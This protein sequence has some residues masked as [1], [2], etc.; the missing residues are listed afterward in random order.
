MKANTK[1]NQVVRAVGLGACLL[2]S[3]LN[4]SAQSLAT[5]PV[6]VTL[7]QNAQVENTVIKLG[8]LAAID[9]DGDLAERLSTVVVGQSPRPGQTRDLYLPQITA[10]VKQAG[11]N[12]EVIAWVGAS[13]Q[14]IT[15]RTPGFRVTA[16]QAAEIYRSELAAKIG[17]DPT[18][19]T[20]EMVNWPD[21]VTPEG[22]P[23]QFRLQQENAALWQ[24]LSTGYVHAP[25]DVL[26]GGKV[27][28]SIRPRAKI[29]VT[30]KAFISTE[31]V[32]RG[33][34]IR[35]ESFEAVERE[36]SQLPSGAVTDPDQLRDKQ[37]AR[38]IKAGNP[39]TAA[40]LTAKLLVR[41]GDTV[42]LT[43]RR[44]GMALTL[45]ARAVSDG[46]MGEEIRVQNADSGRIVSATVTG[47][48]TATIALP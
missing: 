16:A 19:M 26:S 42:T 11:I 44:A 5:A 20:V 36:L 12:P 4:A 25:V 21:V 10:R 30:V 29:S 27:V 45:T 14:G 33:G 3:T 41:R 24:S 17:I 6:T 35:P 18:R 37:A 48:G 22:Q 38:P 39:V 7:K 31:S 32:P 47:P 43:F 2:L 15:V 8:D 9:G 1:L 23:V 40:D 46:A 34:E 13:N 28:E